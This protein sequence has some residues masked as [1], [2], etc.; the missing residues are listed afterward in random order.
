MGTRLSEKRKKSPKADVSR[1]KVME[2]DADFRRKRLLLYWVSVFVFFQ[3]GSYSLYLFQAH[4]SPVVAWFF[5]ANAVIMPLNILLFRHDGKL[6][7][8]LIRFLLTGFTNIIALITPSLD[9]TSIYFIATYPAVTFFLAGLRIGTILNALFMGCF[10]LLALSQAA[11]L[12]TSP[13]TM[14]QFRQMFVA[15]LGIFLFAYVAE[16]VHDRFRKELV[17][18][19]DRLDVIIRRMPVG[20]VVFDA[21]DG[22]PS[23]FNAAAE[24]LLGAPLDARMPLARFAEEYGISD[25][26]GAAFNPDDLP[27][28]VVLRSGA[29]DAVADFF[30]DRDG[31]D[32]RVLHVVSAPIYGADGLVAAAVCVIEDMT[33]RFELDRLKSEFVSLASH[34]IKT[35]LT[36]I[37]WALESVLEDGVSMPEEHRKTLQMALETSGQMG[38]LV[39]DLLNVSRIETGKKFDISRAPTDAVP[40]LQ[41]I[42]QS[43]QGFASQRGVT[44]SLRGTPKTLVLDID[45]EKIHEAFMNLVSNAVKYSK[46]GGEVQVGAS[47]TADDATVFIRD[48][49]IGIPAEYQGQ[50]FTKFFRAPNVIQGIEG[51]GLGLYIVKAII[52]KHGGSVW[53]DSKEDE[54]TTFF[55]RLPKAKKTS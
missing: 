55:V 35:P 44:I 54:G 36:S 9:N 32:R 45:G 19:R 2:E 3:S 18:Q 43:I 49:G 51:T 28:S 13:Y 26:D 30:V 6:K 21:P 52:E 46:D 34:Q 11:G 38:T 50:I 17:A 53:F 12:T 8:A 5:F 24:K 20:I 29:K 14:T 40:L 1:H 16:R 37:A 39:K 15:T 10:V 22:R 48:S 7:P 33:K 4:E 31:K 42:A 41:E 23:A 25:E 27:M 47:E